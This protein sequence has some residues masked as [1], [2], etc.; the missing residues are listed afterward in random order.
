ML[1]VID[2]WHRQCV[3]LK[4]DYRLTG[5][6]VVDAMN[7][8]ALERELPHAITVDH[9]TEFTSKSLDECCYLRG[10][11]LDFIRPGKPTEN[12]FIE[13]FKGDFGTSV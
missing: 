2:E 10:V 9:G 1:T 5:Q 11:K 8:I 7:R 12:A 13:S 4:A 3:A 6:R